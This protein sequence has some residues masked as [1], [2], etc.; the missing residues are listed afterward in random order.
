QESH[1]RINVDSRAPCGI[2]LN[3]YAAIT[4]WLRGRSAS[5]EIHV[6]SHNVSPA[7]R[8]KALGSA[9]VADTGQ[10]V[11]AASVAVPGP[12]PKSSHVAGAKS[13]RAV[14]KAHI[15]AC[16]AAKVAGRRVAA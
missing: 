13:G 9:S 16:T 15:T 11:C 8:M 2:S 3:T 1:R 14:R 4:A 12:A 5:G 6:P 7:R 10:I